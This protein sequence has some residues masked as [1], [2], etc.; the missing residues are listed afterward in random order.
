M[1]ETAQLNDGRS[2]VNSVYVGPIDDEL[3][4]W[5]NQHVLAVQS[6]CQ[7]LK[8]HVWLKSNNTAY[9]QLLFLCCMLSV[10]ITSNKKLTA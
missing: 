1:V 3:M 8:S 10:E 9:M 7:D 4:Y 2:R 5:Q 6:L